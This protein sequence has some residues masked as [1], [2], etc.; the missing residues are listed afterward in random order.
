MEET[1]ESRIAFLMEIVY[2]TKASVHWLD[3]SRTCAV[4]MFEW[5]GET[6]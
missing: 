3:A 1:P 4:G 2:Y 6:P 5:R